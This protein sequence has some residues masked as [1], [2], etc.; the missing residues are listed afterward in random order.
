MIGK[1]NLATVVGSHGTLYVNSSTGKVIELYPDGSDE[2]ADI[3]RFD[4]TEWVQ[5]HC[6]R[7]G[8]P[9]S[10]QR[11]LELA[12]VSVGGLLAGR[13]VDILD[14]GF[15]MIDGTYEP[16]EPE[17]RE[18]ERKAVQEKTYVAVFGKRNVQ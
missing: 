14:L 11:A 13:T 6:A 16:A 18:E 8:S 5:A 17:W 9:V 2:Y 1:V 10:T 7:L 12:S 4:V 15:W 3:V